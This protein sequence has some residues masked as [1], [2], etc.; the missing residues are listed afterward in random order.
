MTAA[1]RKFLAENPSVFD[2]RKY[3]GAGKEAIK[4][5][6]EGKID[7]VLGSKDSL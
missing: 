6:V 2:P 4:A 3:I 7:V 1:I 5:T